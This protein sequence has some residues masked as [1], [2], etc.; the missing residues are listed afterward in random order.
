M[1]FQF[2]T[3]IRIRAGWSAVFLGVVGWAIGTSAVPTI[4]YSHGDPSGEEQYML[5]LINRARSGPTQEGIFLTTQTGTT[6]NQAYTFFNVNKLQVQAAFAAIASIQPLAMNA[7]LLTAARGHSND[8]MTGSYQGHRNPGDASESNPG[9]SVSVTLRLSNVGYSFNALAENVYAAVGGPV[10]SLL[11]AHVGLNIDWGVPSLDHRK[12]IMGLN[13]GTSDYSV[14]REIGVGVQRRSSTISGYEFD[15]FITQ[16]FA[17]SGATTNTPFLVGVVYTDLDADGY[18]P[19]EGAAGVTVMPNVGD[20][21][22]VTS[23]SGGYAIP[24]QNLPQGTTTIT[25]TFSG[26]ALGAGQ[27]VRSIPL[28]GVSNLK[29]DVVLPEDPT[30]RLINLSTRLRVETGA[31]VGIGG[32]VITGNTPKKILVRAIGPSLTA[33]GVSGAMSNPKLE[34]FNSSAIPAVS[35]A[36]NDDWQQTQQAAIMQT[37]LAPSDSREAAI[38]LP[39]LAPGAYTAI[40]SGVAG[41][42]G[43]A[44]IEVYDLDPR[45]V[46][47]RAINVSTRG[48]V[49]TG[50]AVMIGGFVIQGS[51]PRRV[52]I[53][54]LG[55][56]LTALGVQGALSDPWLQLFSG[57]NLVTSN[58]N[59]KAGPSMMEL[60][61]LGRAPSDDREAA[62]IVTLAP[63]PYTVIV[64]GAGGATGVA[65]VEVYDTEN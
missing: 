6:I 17:R 3:N 48:R 62:L 51:S 46:Q 23:T 52:V 15:Y 30:T 34:V 42:M 37:G 8:M 32:F 13:D 43:V 25:V 24:L 55:P 10:P 27:V 18:T 53:R 5:E 4:Q 31:N 54:A 29:A 36:T 21:F 26:G 1:R 11:Y 12:A 35:I 28:S 19:G 14:Y 63:G 33:F 38:L 65:L 47:P 22:A 2:H 7:N 45:T 20:Y 16:D 56:S 40:V 58:D 49:L 9:F 64:N 57:P 50:D 61:A 44:L 60:Q 39:T 59:W 41:E